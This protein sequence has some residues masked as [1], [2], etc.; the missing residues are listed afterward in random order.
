MGTDYDP[1][2]HSKVFNSSFIGPSSYTL[3][4]ANI[5]PVNQQTNIPNIRNDYTVT[6]KADGQRFMMFISGSGKIYLISNNMQVVFT[7]ALTQNKDILNSLV[8]G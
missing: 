3:Q 1:V 5:A 7:G 6:D 8:D 4:M 2:K